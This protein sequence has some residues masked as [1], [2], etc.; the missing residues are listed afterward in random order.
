MPAFTWEI[1]A[2]E[3]EG[4]RVHPSLAPQEF[5]SRGG[6]RVSGIRFRRVSTT[7][8]DSEGRIHWT[9]MEGP[10]S[11][12]SVE[13]I[14]AV[15][16]AIGQS[17]D[18]ASLGGEGLRLSGRGSIVVDEATGETGVPGVFAAGDA[19][20]T[21]GTVTESMA[22]GRTAAQAIDRYLRGEPVIGTREMR[23]VITIRPEQVPAYLTR[24]QRWEMPRLVPKQAIKT[25]KEVELGYSYW[26]ARE[27][28]SR[29]LNCRMCANCIFERG[30]LCFETAS[31]LL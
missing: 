8:L 18:I 20:A 19:A 5:T 28:A 15:V 21:G 31:R 30:Q 24:R 6:N 14:G 10:G 9:L 4:V 29:C 13:G 17:P 2:A 3:R 12:Y 26:Q 25:F 7:W 22:A 1:E 11:E 27:E 16:V 23:Q